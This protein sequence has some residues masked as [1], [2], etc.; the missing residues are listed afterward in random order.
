[1]TTWIIDGADKTTDTA[2]TIR[3]MAPDIG[4]AMAMATKRGVLVERVRRDETLQKPPTPSYWAI[5]VLGSLFIGAGIVGVMAS[6]VAGVLIVWKAMSPTGQAPVSLG[7]AASVAV[8]VVVGLLLV[9]ISL[10]AIGQDCHARR[11][12]A[13]NSHR[14]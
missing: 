5:R 12:I 7:D 13:R 1:M 8:A 4:T 14:A 10:I 2:T 9:S 6:L 3:V 11:D